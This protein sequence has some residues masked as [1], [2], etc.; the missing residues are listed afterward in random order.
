[1]GIGGAGILQANEETMIFQTPGFPEQYLAV[2]RDHLAAYDHLMDSGLSF[3]FFCPPMIV[4]GPKTGQYETS[5]SYPPKGKFQI[6][7]A[8]LAHALVAEIQS[9]RYIG[10]R[11]GIC[12]L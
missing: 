2:S 5:D 11:V 12:A 4:D 8:D 3:T 6:N 9:P 10:K 1:V 7:T